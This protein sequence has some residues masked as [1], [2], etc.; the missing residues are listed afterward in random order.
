MFVFQVITDAAHYSLPGYQLFNKAFIYFRP[1]EADNLDFFVEH[2]IK[3][4]G[5]L[6]ALGAGVGIPWHSPTI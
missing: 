5:K 4:Q 2:L 1:D 3:A 6:V